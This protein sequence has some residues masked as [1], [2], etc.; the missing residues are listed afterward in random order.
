MCVAYMPQHMC[1]GQRTSLW[2]KFFLSVLMWLAEMEFKSEGYRVQSLIGECLQ[3]HMLVWRG[4][5][6]HGTTSVPS[7]F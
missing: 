6:G 7:C 5:E 4:W 1:Q 2:N 3:A